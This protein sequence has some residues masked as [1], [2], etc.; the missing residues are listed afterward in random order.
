MSCVLLNKQLF[1]GKMCPAMKLIATSCPSSIKQRYILPW[2]VRIIRCWPFQEGQIESIEVWQP[3]SRMSLYPLVSYLS[4]REGLLGGWLA[5]DLSAAR[6]NQIRPKITANHLSTREA[7]PSNHPGRERHFIPQSCQDREKLHWGMRYPFY[8]PSKSLLSPVWKHR[9]TADSMGNNCLF[10]PKQW[11]KT[12]KPEPQH[13]AIRHECFIT[14]SLS[15]ELSQHYARG[16]N[17]EALAIHVTQRT[18]TRNSA[19][20]LGPWVIYTRWLKNHK[21]TQKPL[22][23]YIMHLFATEFLELL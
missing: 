16:L 12:I 15:K 20:A 1:C 21:N 22:R 7:I 10:S 8:P 13:I 11:H 3:I 17:K 18:R 14:R 6:R 23:P 5:A 2:T 4:Q 19:G 9:T